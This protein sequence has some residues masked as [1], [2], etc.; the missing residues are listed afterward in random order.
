MAFNPAQ[1]PFL[2]DFQGGQMTDLPAYPGTADLTSLMEIVTPGNAA[3]GVN[4]A[5]N[6]AQLALIIGSGGLPTIIT[7]GATYNSV[8]GDTRILVNKTVGSITTVA[9]LGAASYFQP[10]LI[11]DLKGD[12]GTNPITVTFAGTYDG[13]ASPLTIN[14]NY[15]LLWMN[16]LASGNWYGTQ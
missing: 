10:V 7:S 14:N 8:A 1:N 4:Y 6:L 9:L 16:P 13:N 5:I 3:N 12:A 11:K 15:G 2:N